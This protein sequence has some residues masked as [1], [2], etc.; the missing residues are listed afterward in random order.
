MEV[1]SQQLWVIVRLEVEV[2]GR[3]GRNRVVKGEGYSVGGQGVVDLGEVDL[4]NRGEQRACTN[5]SIKGE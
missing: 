5:R 1:V 3:K 2:K 4:E